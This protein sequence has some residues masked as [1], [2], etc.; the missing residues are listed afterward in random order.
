MV[1]QTAMGFIL[2]LTVID[3]K[4]SSRTA[5]SMVKVLRNLPT[6]IPIKAPTSWENHMD[7]EN[8]IG[9]LGAILK[10]IFKMVWE[11]GKAFGKEVQETVIDM[12]ENIKKTKK[13][14]MEHLFGKMVRFTK[15]IFLTISEMVMDKCIGQMAG[16]IKD[17]G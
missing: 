13:K 17:N 7:M 11:V 1:K 5:W 8:I 14:D 6:E 16:F 12:K 9:Q 3:M 4:G 10:E 15:E 2:G